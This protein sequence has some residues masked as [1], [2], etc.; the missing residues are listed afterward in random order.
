MRL[1]KIPNART[2]LKQATNVLELTENTEQLVSLC[3]QADVELEIGCGKGDFI[4]KRAMEHPQKQYFALEKYDSVLLKA[5]QKVEADIPSNLTFILGDAEHL[6]QMFPPAC[7]TKIYLNFS[8]PWPK[9]K[10]GKRRLT[11]RT[12]LKIYETLLKE[13][14]CLEMKTDNQLLFES[15]LQELSLEHWYIHEV[16]LDLYHTEKY[17]QIKRFQTEYEKKFIQKNQRIYYLQASKLLK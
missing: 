13:T 17:E 4:I 1:R 2:Y 16:S 5:V 10:H 8:D 11:Y 12:K 14:G 15:T 7:L 3:E 6:L 9:K